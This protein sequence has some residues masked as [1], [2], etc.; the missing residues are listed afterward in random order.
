MDAH[1]DPME[2]V[3]DPVCGMEF[4]RKKAV[5]TV[6]YH[7]RRIHFCTEACRRRFERDPATFV[8]NGSP[9]DSAASDL[10]S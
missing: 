9:E 6:L 8:M 7:G 10:P 3:V 5:A 4:R 1:G 2:K